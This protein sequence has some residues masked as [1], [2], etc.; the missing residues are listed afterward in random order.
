MIHIA[1]P[2]TLKYILCG[3]LL[4]TH[5]HTFLGGSDYEGILLS[6][7]SREVRGSCGSSPI[8]PRVRVH[9]NFGYFNQNYHYCY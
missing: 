1:T 5:G 4:C 8:D 2:T 3:D 9:L 7:F 6:F